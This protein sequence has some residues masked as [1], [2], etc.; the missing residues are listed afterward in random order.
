MFKKRLR[1][2]ANYLESVP[3]ERF[4]LHS[5]DCGTTACAVGYACKIPEFEQAG[6]GLGSSGQPTY[7]GRCFGFTAAAKFFGISSENAHKLFDANYYREGRDGVK[8]VV[9]KIRRFISDN[10]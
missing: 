1:T 8:A 9:N 2:L 3:K 5:W 10:S 7:N 6:L 4:D